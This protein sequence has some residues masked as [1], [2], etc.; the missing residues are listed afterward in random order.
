MVSCQPDVDI[1]NCAGV[2]RR[3][4]YASS[5]QYQI[6]CRVESPEASFADHVIFHVNV[7]VTNKC[8]VCIGRDE[9]CEYDTNTSQ[10]LLGSVEVSC[11][12]A[13]LGS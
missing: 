9:F 5:Q 2:C 3:R 12:C 13:S 8:D 10:Q 7:V 1:Q 4:K 6:V 11:P